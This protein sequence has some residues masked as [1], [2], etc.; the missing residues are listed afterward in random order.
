MKTLAEVRNRIATR[1]TGRPMAESKKKMS[2]D[3][4]GGTASKLNKTLAQFSKRNPGFGGSVVRSTTRMLVRMRSL[5]FT[6]AM[7]NL[8]SLS[9]KRTLAGCAKF[10]TWLRT[11]L[12]A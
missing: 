7:R 12:A 3:P 10:M 8:L 11:P 1:L 9:K 4:N 2:V 6:D 5:E